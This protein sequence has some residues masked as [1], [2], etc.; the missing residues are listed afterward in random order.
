M[1]SLHASSRKKTAGQKRRERENLTSEKV[2]AVNLRN[3]IKKLTAIL[4]HN[5]ID[6]DYH[7]TLTYENEPGKA[8]AKADLDRFLRNIRNYCKRNDIDWRRVAVTEYENHRIHHHIVCS[9]IDPE[10]INRYWRYG[11]V[12]FKM[13]SSQGNYYKLAEYLVKETEKTFRK[14]DAVS[15]QRYSP[16]RNIVIPQPKVEEVSERQIQQDPKPEKGYYIDKET[17]RRYEHAIFETECMEYIMVSLEADPPIKRYKRGKKGRY[18]KYYK[19]TED[20]LIF[21]LEA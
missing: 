17:I 13:L 18:E 14:P 9:G 19:A 4:N 10:V 20:Q 7:L 15:R 2:I 8:E 6:G 1:R 11:F 12:N 16:S 5:F 21:D 3:A